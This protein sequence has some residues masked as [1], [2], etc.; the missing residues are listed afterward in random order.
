MQIRNPEMQSK[1]TYWKEFK[2]TEKLGEGSYGAVY[3]IMHKRTGK[4]YSLKE[5]NLCQQQSLK[6]ECLPRHI[7]H[8]NIIK[9]TRLFMSRRP[10]KLQRVVLDNSNRWKCKVDVEKVRDCIEM[11]SKDSIFS[12]GL[13]SLQTY[14]SNKKYYYMI[15]DYCDC[16]LN[17]FIARR[18]EIFFCNNELNVML[19]DLNVNMQ[20]SNSAVGRMAINDIHTE[21][22]N[23]T[24][25]KMHNLTTKT[26]FSA[27]KPLTNT[28]NIRYNPASIDNNSALTHLL[29]K[30]KISAASFLNC[31]QK[32]EYQQPYC[33]IKVDTNNKKYIDRRFIAYLFKD[34]VRGVLYLHAN[35]IYHCDIKSNN[36]LLKNEN[37]LI[38]K[39]SDFGLRRTARHK[40]YFHKDI[41]K[42]GII[43]FEMLCPVRTIMEM[44]KLRHDLKRKKKFPNWFIETYKEETEI[45]TKCITKKEKYSISARWLFEAV[46]NLCKKL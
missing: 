25:V 18:N 13:S 30:G 35:N 20:S 42:C 41:F 8:A 9:Y 10:E 45:I 11:L 1:K 4:L 40:K 7:T 24:N 32:T 36:V 46:V 12:D 14:D 21:I 37:I 33:G 34:I 39:I 19:N 28:H 16:T 22:Y 26:N 38:P 2:F 15:Y 23:N 6:N 44:D 27:F 3:K 31:L 29:H 5:I 17:E 43:Y